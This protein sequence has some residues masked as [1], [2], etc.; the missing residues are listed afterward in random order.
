MLR[1]DKDIPLLIWLRL[2]WLYLDLQSHDCLPTLSIDTSNVLRDDNAEMPADFPR[3]AVDKQ[4]K[5]ISADAPR[6]CDDQPKL[7]LET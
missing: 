5:R 3:L 6:R 2:G 1:A 4:R 7:F